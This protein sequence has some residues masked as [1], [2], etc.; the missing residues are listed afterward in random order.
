MSLFCKD[1]ILKSEKLTTE[2]ELLKKTTAEGL[3]L[4]GINFANYK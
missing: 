2:L 1:Y 4:Y 3:K